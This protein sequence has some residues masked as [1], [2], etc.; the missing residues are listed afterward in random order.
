MPV[1]K[2]NVNCSPGVD[3]GRKCVRP[4]NAVTNVA[5]LSRGTFGTSEATKVLLNPVTGRRHQVAHS[6]LAL[7]NLFDFVYVYLDFCKS[8]F[9]GKE[10]S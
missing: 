4:R 2:E 1:I 8:F 10:F 3:G 5:V 7:W 9:I 6:N